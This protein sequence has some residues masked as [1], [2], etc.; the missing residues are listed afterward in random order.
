MTT[1]LSVARV[2]EPGRGPGWTWQHLVVN[3][4]EV[5]VQVADRC[6][7]AGSQEPRI[8]GDDV[9]RDIVRALAAAPE[10]L[11][12]LSTLVAEADVFGG[13]VRSVSRYAV[14]RARVA[15]AKATGDAS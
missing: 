9:L 15:L 6:D 3:G 11:A 4:H 12:A 13:R 10:L 2:G 1:P 7:E 5:T 8:R 14:D